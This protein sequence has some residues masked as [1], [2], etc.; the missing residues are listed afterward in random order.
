MLSTGSHQNPQVSPVANEKGARAG[1]MLQL[2]K[3]RL[4]TKTRLF[5]GTMPAYLRSCGGRPHPT[6]PELTG[7]A[8]S[9]PGQKALPSSFPVSVTLCC[10]V[11]GILACRRKW[12]RQM[13]LHAGLPERPD[14]LW[15]GPVTLDCA[16]CFPRL[17]G[18]SLSAVRVRIFLIFVFCFCF[19]ALCCLLMYC[20]FLSD[21]VLIFGETTQ[22]Y[23]LVSFY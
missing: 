10:Q 11:T 8:V 6:W 20:F 13:W 16:I 15:G 9:A 19:L 14:S 3:A 1:E 12:I 7:C 2:L 5:K 22:T 21:F 17:L 23:L 4:I 18:Q